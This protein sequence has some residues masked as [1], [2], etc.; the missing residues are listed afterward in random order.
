MARVPTHTVDSAPAGSRE[1]VTA[2][3]GMHGRVL[4][5]IGVMAN[6]PATVNAYASLRDALGQHGTLDGRA[7]EAIALAVAE[8][9]QCDYCLAAHTMA[10]Q[11]QGFSTDDTLQIRRGRLPGDPKLD[12][13]VALV[14]EMTDRAGDVTDASWAAALDAGWTEAEL[15]ESVTH[16]VLNVFTNFINRALRT[17]LD[18]PAAPRLV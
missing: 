7:R 15:T 17:D 5:I 10:G 9:N 1:T 18:F 14:Y 16:V 2:F 13:L 11:R 8:V 3:N 6:A 4:N 12:K